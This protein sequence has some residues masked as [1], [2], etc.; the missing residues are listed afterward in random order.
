MRSLKFFFFLKKSLLFPLII[1]FFS[2]LIHFSWLSYP[3]EV[4]FDEVHFGKF[5]SAYFT[6]KY[7]FD[8]H[9]PLGKLIIAGGS[10]LGG[11]HNYLSI[12]PP[13][14]F[15]DIGEKFSDLPFLGFRFF[16][17]LAGALLPLTIYW[18]V[19][20]L[21]AST[22]TA[23]IASFFILSETTFLTQSR[24]ILLDSFLLLFGFLGLCFFLS[25]R[26]KNYPLLL[27]FLAGLFLGASFSVKWTGL[28]F[29]GLAGIFLFIDWLETNEKF[30]FSFFSKKF[31]PLA[32]FKEE[33][34]FKK[35]FSFLKPLIIILTTALAVYLFA[36]AVHFNLLSL[37][38]DGDAFMEENFRQHQI[39]FWEKFLQLNQKIN[40]YNSNLKGT[41]PDASHFW[42]W[43]ILKK[44]IHY[45]NDGEARIIFFGNPILWLGGFLAI[46]LF[47]IF[48]KKI[49]LSSKNKFFLL[50][51]FWSNFLPFLS[52]T[53]AL[54]LYHY[55]SAL[56]FSLIMWAI[57]F[58][59]LICFKNRWGKIFQLS[60]FGLVLV[61]FCL[62][63]FLAYGLKP[64]GDWHQ[65]I[66]DMILYY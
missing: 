16:P 65:K 28:S 19:R 32:T 61:G 2:L 9:P 8:I 58:D 43:P 25:A 54:F 14:E 7:F 63:S 56:T 50:V 45:W 33:S 24:F 4:V 60:F 10:Y 5:A 64:L 31:S 17:A 20:L 52:V 44:P 46:I 6:G 35:L 49:P 51:G 53:R 34:F 21:G 15:K 59:K 40:F 18:L 55:L 3:Q 11:Y 26:K 42:Q 41:H 62:F 13:F 38:G 47:I 23:L 30:F 29:L 39:G 27:T 57:V 37:P 36:F 12:H 66:L 1:L 22:K 48:W